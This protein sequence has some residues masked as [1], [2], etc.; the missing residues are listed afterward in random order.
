MARTFG[1][2][3]LD[4]PLRLRDGGIHSFFFLFSEVVSCAQRDSHLLGIVESNCAGCGTLHVRFRFYL[5]SAAFL[6]AEKETQVAMVRG[7]TSSWCL[8]IKEQ[9]IALLLGCSFLTT[10]KQASLKIIATFILRWYT[11]N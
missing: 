5:L 3:M 8:S 9:S 1:H 10:L 11:E 6:Q 7:L 4:Q 2:Q